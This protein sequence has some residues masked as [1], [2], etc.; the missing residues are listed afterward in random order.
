MLGMPPIM[1][2][3]NSNSFSGI[4]HLNFY[5]TELDTMGVTRLRDFLIKK[6]L[7]ET[8]GFHNM[9]LQNKTN[10]FKKLME[11]VRMGAKI[12][13]ISLGGFNFD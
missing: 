10:D 8:I 13:K 4:K 2:D 5:D 7:I 11:G 3:P 1:P 12:R 6:P 9:R